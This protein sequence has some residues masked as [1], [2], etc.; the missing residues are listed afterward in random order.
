MMMLRMGNFSAKLFPRLR[1]QS[2][3]IILFLSPKLRL[4]EQS[5][6]FRRQ[7]SPHLSKYD[8]VF[9]LHV[10][11]MFD[12]WVKDGLRFLQTK[13]HVSSTVPTHASCQLLTTLIVN[14]SQGGR[15]AFAPTSNSILTLT[16]SPAFFVLRVFALTYFAGLI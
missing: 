8:L 1:I 9:E 6:V 2:V 4:Y 11:F 15:K 10:S 12:S 3:L 5:P 14:N 16:A 13:A 7:M